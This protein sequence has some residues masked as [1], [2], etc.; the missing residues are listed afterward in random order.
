MIKPDSIN[1]VQSFNVSEEFFS[2]V[3]RGQTVFSLFDH[4]KEHLH[5]MQLLAKSK[6]EQLNQ[7]VLDEEENPLV[8]LLYRVMT[9]QNQRFLER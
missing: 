3:F 9:F 1:D 7:D 4:N 2:S 6:L 5:Q 8:R